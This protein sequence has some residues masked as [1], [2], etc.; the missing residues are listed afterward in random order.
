MDLE[1][2]AMR[3]FELSTLIKEHFWRSAWLVFGHFCWHKRLHTD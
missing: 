1:G 3:F 2:L